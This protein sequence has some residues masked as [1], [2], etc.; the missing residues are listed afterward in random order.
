MFSRIVSILVL[1]AALAPLTNCNYRG[2]KSGIHWFLDMQDSPA[3][4][5]QEEDFTTLSNVKGSAWE[6]G[7]DEHEAFGGPGSGVRVPPEGTVPRNFEPY[8]FAAADFV[9]PRSLHNPLPSSAEV[10][11]RGQNRYNTY[12]A[13]CHG[14]TGAGDGPVTPRFPDMPS[15]LTGKIKDWSDGEIFHIVTMG[16]ARMR[17]YAYQLPVDDRWAV[18]RYVRLLQSR[19]PAGA[20]SGGGNN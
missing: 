16:R 2:N 8:P 5:A 9:G 20:T 1:L 7:A 3:V 11:A 6:R 18:I 15:L 4:E 12:C 14:Y 13:T 17:P 10:L 19:A